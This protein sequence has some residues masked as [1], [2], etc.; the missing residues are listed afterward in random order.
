M[1]ELFWRIGKI[2][3]EGS[4]EVLKLPVKRIA[5]DEESFERSKAGEPGRERSEAV[6][7]DCESVKAREVGE[8]TRNRSKTARVGDEDEQ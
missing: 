7:S 8:R 5:F 2:A 6:V 1:I 4:D 3:D